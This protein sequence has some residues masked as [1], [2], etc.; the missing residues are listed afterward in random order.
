[1]V[2]FSEGPKSNYYEISIL[3][4]KKISFY[5]KIYQLELNFT[6]DAIY[7]RPRDSTR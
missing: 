6:L 5:Q 4:T 7:S 3:Y 2:E 1:M